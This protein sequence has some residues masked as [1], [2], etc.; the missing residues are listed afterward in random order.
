MNAGGVMT[1]SVQASA[2]ARLAVAKHGI[3]FVDRLG[4]PRARPEIKI[5]LDSRVS[6][7]RLLRELA[8]DAEPPVDVPRPPALR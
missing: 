4:S 6:F 2:A 8:I 3:T 5:E 1:A 7:A